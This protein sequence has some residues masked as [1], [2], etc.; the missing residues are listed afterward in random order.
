MNFNLDLLRL[1]TQGA[2]RVTQE[3]NGFNFYRFTEIE[4]ELYKQRN[5]G[6]HIRCFAT[7]GVLL[8]FKT[9][10]KNLFIS[11]EILQVGSRSYCS[12][13]VFVNG[14]MIDGIDN[15]SHLNLPADYAEKVYAIGEFKKN[16]PLCDG[17]K[18]I[19]IYLP[20]AVKAV[21]KE[22][23]LDDGSTVT[24]VKP[25]HKLLAYGDSITHGFDALN[26][27]CKYI[28][29][30]A[31]Y[32]DAEEINKAIGGE[33]FWPE[34]VKNK[35]DFTPD[36][37]TVAYGTNDW[38]RLTSQEE[39][40]LNCKGF[41]ENLKNNYKN[42]PIYAITPIWR[43][44]FEL[45]D[46]PFGKF[47]KVEEIIKKVAEEIGGITVIPGFNLVEHNENLFGDLRLHPN[48]AGFKQYFESL[49]KYF[50]K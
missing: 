40:Y 49:T 11:G 36:F 22:L 37:I 3:E 17:E 24:P 28:T 10:S 35:L 42:T 1:V 9:N 25:K 30:L 18:E 33:F 4:E 45:N 34:L 15:F 29:K 46:R 41:F 47:E 50:N 2:A 12:I 48:N 5:E 21:I 26:P 31:E 8:C 44:D 43:K 19:K 14:E 7:S 27:P 20:L 39:L 23:T 38:A 32:L 6:S 16:I 13:D